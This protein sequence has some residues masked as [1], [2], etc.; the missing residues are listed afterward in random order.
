MTEASGTRACSSRER[1][2]WFLKSPRAC[3]SR[4]TCR[5]ARRCGEREIRAP[6]RVCVGCID[7]S[8]DSLEQAETAEEVA[9]RIREALEI[10]MSTQ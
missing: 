4:I 2:M 6:K 8:R 10:V 9:G 1:E 3:A 5:A 7:Q